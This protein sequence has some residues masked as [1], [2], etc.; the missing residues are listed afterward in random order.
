MAV[1]ICGIEALMFGSLMILG[2]R[3]LPVLPILTDR[4]DCFCWA[5]GS[6]GKR[7]R[8]RPASEMSLNSTIT[9]A[10]L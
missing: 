4:P 5:L 6:P 10:A 7:K 9:P 8:I 3:L 2:F 1:L